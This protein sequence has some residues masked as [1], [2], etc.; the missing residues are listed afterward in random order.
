MKIKPSRNGKITLSFIGIVKS[1]LSRE[2]F[3]SLRCVLMLFL[4]IKFSQKFP[5][6]QYYYS[7]RV[8]FLTAS[9]LIYDWMVKVAAIF[10][11]IIYM[12]EYYITR[13]C[14]QLQSSL[15]HV[16]A[17]FYYTLTSYNSQIY[18][19]KTQ[20]KCCV[21]PLCGISSA[22]ALFDKIKTI[23][24]EPCIFKFR[25]FDLCEKM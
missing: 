24:W 25:N 23:F 5:N 10:G 2:I 18:T 3:T 19:T 15:H 8:L 21:M 1:C 16:F 12:C 20:M 17:S 7:V 11:L 6:L 4:K 22:S 13:F 9:K 14:S